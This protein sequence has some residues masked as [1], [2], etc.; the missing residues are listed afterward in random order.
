VNEHLAPA[1][2]STDADYRTVTIISRARSLNT[3]LAQRTDLTSPTLTILR[4][5]LDEFCTHPAA[6]LELEP[7][8]TT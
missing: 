1:L 3:L 7:D 4:N 5:D 6:P 2:R 8:S